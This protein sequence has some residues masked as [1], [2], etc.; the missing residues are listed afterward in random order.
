MSDE[1]K[2]LTRAGQEA[3]D[4]VLRVLCNVLGKDIIGFKL[5]CRDGKRIVEKYG[6]TL[7]EEGGWKPFTE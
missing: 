7:L 4:A 1:L 6:G 5:V 2:Q 3:S